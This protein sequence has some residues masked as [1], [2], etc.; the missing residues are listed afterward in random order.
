MP[1]FEQRVRGTTLS[2]AEQGREAN[3]SHGLLLGICFGLAFF[4]VGLIASRMSRSGKG[5]LRGDTKAGL[6]ALLKT[7]GA[8]ADLAIAIEQAIQTGDK[9]LAIKVCRELT[10]MGLKDAKAHVEAIMRRT[11]RE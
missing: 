9:I 2:T 6:D 8:R 10:G 7:A 3:L 11:G 5:R 1:Q 4:A